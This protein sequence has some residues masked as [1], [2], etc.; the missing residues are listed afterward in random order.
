MSVF[1]RK[2]SAKGIYSYEFVRSGHRFS[3][4]TGKTRKTDAEKYERDLIN[5]VE[6]ELKAN[7]GVLANELTL[8][9]GCARR[10]ADVGNTRPDRSRG[11][12]NYAWLLDQLGFSTKLR[13]ID[14]NRIAAMIAVRQ[15]HS[16]RRIKNG[17]SRQI[18]PATVNATAIGPT[19][20]V[21]VRAR[22]TWKVR[23]APVRWSRLRLKEPQERIREA[24]LSEENALL[25][26][27]ARGYDTAT[28]FLFQT[29]LRRKEIIG[30]TWPD[31]DWFNRRISVLGKGNKRRFVPLSKKAFAILLQVKD[32]HVEY[33]FTFEA[34]F[35]RRTKYGM[36]QEKGK[37]YPLTHEGFSSAMERAVK[38]AN[39]SDFHMHD[40]RHTT[41]SRVVRGS[42]L[43]VAQRLLGHSDI[44]TTMRYVHAHDDDVRNALDS[45]IPTETPTDLTAD[46]VTTDDQ[47][48]ISDVRG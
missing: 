3:G 18:G 35:S 15:S 40:I 42:N 38:K 29:G 39:L 48:E 20:H 34:K 2:D 33:V 4:S 11:L 6:A 30:L 27:V 9:A 23:V 7:G 25:A 14:E 41:A 12:K 13:D 24:T 22:D 5:K 32:Q 36:V 44:R 31:V 46:D 21:I 17:E 1:Q 19:Q 47:R 28:R 8:E 43:K 16:D 37:R 45:A 26:K 10:L